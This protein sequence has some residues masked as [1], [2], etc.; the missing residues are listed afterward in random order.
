[1]FVKSVKREDKQTVVP[2]PGEAPL[3][4]ARHRRERPVDQHGHREPQWTHSDTSTTAQNE[5]MPARPSNHTASK[6]PRWIGPHFTSKQNAQDVVRSAIERE[7][8]YESSDSEIELDA[9]SDSEVSVSQR[10]LVRGAIPIPVNLLVSRAR[11]EPT[12][13]RPRT[14]NR[15]TPQSPRMRPRRG[16]SPSLTRHYALFRQGM[17]KNT[18]SQVAMLTEAAAAKVF[19]V[20]TTSFK[21]K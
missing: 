6:Q 11:P 12:R 10:S 14:D 7:S 9:A 16:P 13:F 15:E 8:S 1:M 20:G 3:P 2:V 21:A 17:T 4:S 19:N 18:L 5:T